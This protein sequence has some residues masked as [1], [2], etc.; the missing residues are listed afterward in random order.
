M[1]VFDD[2]WLSTRTG[3]ALI[4]ANARYWRTVA[5]LVRTQLER[6]Q[7]HAEAIPDPTLQATALLNLREEGFNAQ[8]TATLATLAPHRHRKSVVEA[9]VGL[10]TMYDYLDSLVERPLADP[11]S[12]GQR[13]Y[14]AFL[15]AVLP[16]TEPRDDYYPQPHSDDGG[17][18]LELIDVVRRALAQLPRLAAV[19]EVAERAAERCAEAQ[20]RAH[21]APLLGSAQLERWAQR[22]AAGTGLQWPEFLAGA[23]SSGLALHALIAAAA[24]PRTTH[25]QAI[26]LDHAYLSICALTTLLDSVIDYEQDIYGTGRPGYL[27]YYEDR[28]AL[29]QGLRAVLHRATGRTREVPDGAHHLVTLIGVVAYYSS[30]PTASSPW[31]RHVISEISQELQPLITPT[32]AVMRAWRFLK[33]A[34]AAIPS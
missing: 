10:Q 22:N 5:P 30:A 20:V 15:D 29:A 3:L 17:Y 28:E 23:V 18:L 27:R 21:A 33:R 25:G 8:A 19:T 12:D 14:Q 26:A 4:L 16:D 6:W 34:R 24:D 13:L 1:S 7:E 32:H 31:A 2:R 11:L 9:I